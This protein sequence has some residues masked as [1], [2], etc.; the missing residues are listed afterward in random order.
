[1]LS[2]NLKAQANTVEEVFRMYN[3]CSR[4]L[5]VTD[6]ELSNKEQAG[7]YDTEDAAAAMMWVTQQVKKIT[8]LNTTRMSELHEAAVRA[9]EV[10]SIHAA[11]AGVETNLSIVKQQSEETI[12]GLHAEI[13]RRLTHIN[14]P[15]T[16]PKLTFL[17]SAF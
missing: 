4:Y 9:K 11:K 6:Y 10:D 15:S 3:M 2:Q 12:M 5:A 14:L 13:A 8:T 1:M 16:P 17:S 7:T